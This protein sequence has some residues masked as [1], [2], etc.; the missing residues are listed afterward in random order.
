MLA[1]FG[2]CGGRYDATLSGVVTLD[3]TPVP[4]GTVSFAPT[5]GGPIAYSRIGSD[6]SYSVQTG[7]DRGLPSGEYLVTV[8]ANE[9]PDASKLAPGVP[10]PDGKPITP[11]WYRSTKT[12]GLKFNVEHGKNTYNLEL[13]SQPP[14]GWK[15]AG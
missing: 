1:S 8:I 3:G 15:A 10:P 9:L 4:R 13:T 2:G 12:S 5:G 11:K 7:R 14:A 6:G